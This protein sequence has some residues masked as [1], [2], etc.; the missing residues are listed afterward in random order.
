MSI[1]KQ[2]DTDLESL[3]KSLTEMGRSSADAVEN[4]LEALCVADADAAAAIVKG[5]AR[6][7]NMERD[8]EHRCMTL[9]LRQQPVAGDLRRISTAMKVVTDIER[10]GDHAADIA[11]IIPHLVTVRKEGD[12]A[13]S[14]AIAMGKKAHQM[15]L[16][17]LAALMAEDEL[18]ARKVIAADDAVDYDF[19]AIKHQLAQEIAED[20]GKVDAALD[21]L[22]VI[23]YLERIGD[24]AVNVAE[25]VQFAR[26]GRYKDESMF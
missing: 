12:P 1:R 21:L 11:E 2:Y 13:V 14:Q 24:H 7:N 18:A 8:I 10:I 3:K 23:K 4:V 20:P 26:T 15:I 16:D 22:M 5:D 9:L 6:I 25:W 19:N 17:A